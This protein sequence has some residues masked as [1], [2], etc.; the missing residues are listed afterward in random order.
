MPA[1]VK[2]FPNLLC[3]VKL[4]PKGQ[5][6]KQE[7]A[8]DCRKVA[9]FSE[10]AQAMSRMSESTGIERDMTTFHEVINKNQAV[11]ISETQSIHIPTL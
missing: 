2:R 4:C 6:Y 5:R 9:V 10:E 8:D 7:E 1:Y 11:C 3:T